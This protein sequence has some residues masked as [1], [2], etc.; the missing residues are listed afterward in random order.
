ME[1]V[2]EIADKLSNRSSNFLF[3]C[4]LIIGGIFISWALKYLIKQNKD[5][6]KRLQDEQDCHEEKQENTARLYREDCQRMVVVIDRNTNALDRCRDI[7]KRHL[8]Q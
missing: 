8:E 7:M 4:A 6:V 2:L 3:I 5:I 1:K